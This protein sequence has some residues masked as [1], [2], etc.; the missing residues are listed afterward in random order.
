MHLESTGSLL[1]NCQA[2]FQCCLQ[3]LSVF[4]VPLNIVVTHTFNHGHRGVARLES[5]QQLLRACVRDFLAV[6]GLDDRRRNRYVGC[7]LANS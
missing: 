4:L 1:R 5:A 2:S 3:S 6:L 7:E